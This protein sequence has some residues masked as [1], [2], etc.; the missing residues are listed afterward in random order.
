[1]KIEIT[2]TY[3]NREN[4]TVITVDDPDDITADWWQDEVFPHT[5]D[6]RGQREPA[7][8]EAE[9]LEAQNPHHVGLTWDWG[10]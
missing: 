9:I 3:A 1:M 8:Y 6:G 5:G 10:G 2:N 4:T 7:W